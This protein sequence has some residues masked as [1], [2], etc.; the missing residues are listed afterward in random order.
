MENWTEEELEELE[1][2]RR[3]YREMYRTHAP[4][5]ELGHSFE[6]YLMI[7]LTLVRNA[8]VELKEQMEE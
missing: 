2:M 4:S 1:K 5:K 3:E 8:Y 7:S 6:D